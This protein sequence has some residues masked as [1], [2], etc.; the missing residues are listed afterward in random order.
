MKK[1]IAIDMDEV[2]ADTMQR[3]LDLYNS[4]FELALT[5]AHFHGC[6][7]FDIVAEQHREH[8][9]SYFHREDFFASIAVMKDSQEVIRALAAEHEIFVVS[10]AM[11][12]PCSFAAKYEWLQRYFPFIPSSRIVFCGDKSI[13]FADYLIDDNVRQLSAFRGEGILFSAP[14]NAR[15]TRFRRV[16]NWK[17]VR[18]MFLPVAACR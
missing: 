12:V 14:H 17:E 9:I 3:C 13:I 6:S 5:P 15:E 4:D 18:D 7:L 11:E 2:M 8:V 10:A 16:A 1:R